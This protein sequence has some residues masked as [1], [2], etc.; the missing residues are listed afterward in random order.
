MSD[1]PRAMETK[2]S[3][4]GSAHLRYLQLTYLMGH[5]FIALERSSEMSM[6]ISSFPCFPG[7]SWEQKVSPILGDF[8]PVSN[9]DVTL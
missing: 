1:L 3:T 7:F 5:C 8:W 9:Y 2:Q 4:S 6:T